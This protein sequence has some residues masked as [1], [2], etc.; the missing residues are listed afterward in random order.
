MH[1][2]ILLILLIIMAGGTPCQ[3][4]TV[5]WNFNSGLDQQD[6]DFVTNPP[7]D[8]FFRSKQL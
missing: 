5:T 2:L 1:Y 8:I 7:P 4:V 3:G 6:F